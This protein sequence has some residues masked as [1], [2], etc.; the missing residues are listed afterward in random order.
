VEELHRQNPQLQFVWFVN[1]MMKLFGGKFGFT[2]ET[3]SE[4]IDGEYVTS[5]ELTLPIITTYEKI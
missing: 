1:D 3:G 5:M 4:G 2:D